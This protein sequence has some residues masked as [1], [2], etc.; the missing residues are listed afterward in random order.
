[1]KKALKIF[2]SFLFIIFGSSNLIFASKNFNSLK[3]ETLTTNNIDPTFP[4]LVFNLN[5]TTANAVAKYV[6]VNGTDT[7]TKKTYFSIDLTGKASSIREFFT[8][9]NGNIEWKHNWW[10][11]GQ[12]NKKDATLWNGESG[13]WSFSTIVNS[14]R[15]SEHKEDSH[16]ADLILEMKVSGLRINF[17]LTNYVTAYGRGYQE[18]LNKG[19][20]NSV[21]F[22]SK[23]NWIKSNGYRSKF[24]KKLQETIKI[25][26][27][28][29][30]LLASYYRSKIEAEIKQRI[31]SLTYF[32]YWNQY[33]DLDHP[34]ISI[35][36]S[37]ALG[38]GH[39]DLTFSKRFEAN[40]V[41]VNKF[42]NLSFR[43]IIEINLNTQIYKDKFDTEFSK[44]LNLNS[45]QVTEGKLDSYIYKVFRENGQEL[46]KFNTKE[47][48]GE[49]YINNPKIK[50][51]PVTTK[52]NGQYMPL[53]VKMFIED[54]LTNI[55]NKK[56]LKE[57][58]LTKAWMKHKHFIID[59][60]YK[61]KNYDQ[62]QSAH[63]ILDWS[64]ADSKQTNIQKFGTWEKDV[65][66]NLNI[67]KFHQLVAE[68]DGRDVGKSMYARIDLVGGKVLNSVGDVIDDLPYINQ[69]I[70][71][72]IDTSNEITT[73]IFKQRKWYS[74][75]I[76]FNFQS[77]NWQNDIGTERISE[78][79]KIG[80]HQLP[81]LNG[82]YSQLISASSKIE[83]T[84]TEYN[85]TTII[86]QYH[87]IQE[88]NISNSI[89]KSD[90]KYS[91][92]EPDKNPDQKLLITETI[93]DPENPTKNIPNPDY[94]PQIDHET[95]TKKQLVWVKKKPIGS[96]LKDPVLA[97][98]TLD[99][100]NGENGFLAEASISPGDGNRNLDFNKENDFF[101]YQ[102]KMNDFSLTNLEK[103]QNGGNKF[104][105]RIFSDKNEETIGKTG[106]YFYTI[107][108]KN[109]TGAGTIHQ[110]LYKIFYIPSLEDTKNETS[111]KYP[112]FLE[113]QAVINANIYQDFWQSIQGQHLYAYL[114]KKHPLEVA[115]PS[116]LSCEGVTMYRRE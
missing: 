45:F 33:I 48:A 27:V 55:L 52:V 6:G 93:P 67:A 47:D 15:L 71:D 75:P 18:T 8:E 69:D 110:N 37:N 76:S 64:K 51:I 109:K 95:G 107:D 49:D 38:S 72:Q 68:A 78:T 1:M 66:V 5:I 90:L 10:K 40:S 74:G 86:K 39:V 29:T 4:D 81:S 91:N 56:V 36:D 73:I 43:I 111:Q 44:N 24:Q 25:N 20:I 23:N 58:A 79:V 94:D 99:F 98:G 35:I 53:T 116:G 41:I 106:L 13:K 96:F 100:E 11:N 22:K 28:E 50:Y 77:N 57:N 102:K 82:L 34:K 59:H 115:N 7:G 26:G 112:N 108:V 14:K 84:R 63:V 97:D 30:S 54:E 19:W 101:W 46:I 103:N 87:L 31:R 65:Q 60:H 89:I 88:I 32:N 114:L 42:G 16:L 9:Y 70:P 3:V 17:T 12:S 2:I 92:W 80:D 61:G 105:Q 113:N 21:T 62:Y 104:G 83:I 85:K